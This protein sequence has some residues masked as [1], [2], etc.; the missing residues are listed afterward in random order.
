MELIPSAFRSDAPEEGGVLC[1]HEM[2]SP[3]QPVSSEYNGDKFLVAALTRASTRS[4]LT[5]V[6]LSSLGS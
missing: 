1:I 2:T 3:N 6:F 5:R 4:A